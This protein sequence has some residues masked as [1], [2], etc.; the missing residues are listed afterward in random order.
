MRR[1]AA[2]LV[3]PFACLLTSSMARQGYTQAT[4]LNCSVTETAAKIALQDMNNLATSAQ[5]KLPILDEIRRL[6]AKATD[7][8]K[9]VGAE[10]SV[11]DADRFSTLSQKLRFI[12]ANDLIESR[13]ARDGQAIARMWQLS[14]AEYTA[15]MRPGDQ[16]PDATYY[17]FL[18]LL[19]LGLGDKV[20][21]TTPRVDACDLRAAIYFSEGQGIRWL[22]ENSHQL[23]ISNRQIKA[24]AARYQRTWRRFA[25]ST[26]SA[27]A[28]PYWIK[29][30]L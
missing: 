7:P 19:R 30:I 16:E 10:L 20:T 11:K 4:P 25:N 12:T 14:E 28:R 21:I 24:L 29:T 23:D 6:N 18:L 8:N 26:K 17:G 2:A 5:V 13:H 3:L 15:D 27:S 22:N 1:A 9:P